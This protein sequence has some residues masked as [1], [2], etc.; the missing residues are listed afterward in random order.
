MNGNRRPVALFCATFLRPEMLHIHRQISGLSGFS[1]V[2]ITQKREG[3]WTAERVEVV[4]RAPWRFVGRGL[5]RWL[6]IP[7]QISGMEMRKVRGILRSSEAALLH[8]FF[9]NV[10]IHTIPLI[11][12]GG[13]PAVISFHGSDVTGQI[14]T[15]AFAAARREMFGGVRLV[16]CRSQQLAER[17]AALGCEASK[18]RI[19]RTVLPPIVR[20]PHSPP[21]DGRWH[22]VQASRLVPKKGIATALRAFAAFLKIHPQAKFTIA[23]EGPLEADLRALTSSLGISGSVEFRG[24]LSQAAL[25]ELYASAHIFLH[26][27]ETV[28]GDVEGIP[29]SLLEAM[30][31]GLP[32]VVTDHGGIPEVIR[33]GITGV[34]CSER[35][36]LGLSRSL[37]LLAEDPALYARLSLSGADFVSGEFSAAKQIANIENLYREAVAPR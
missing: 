3:D 32:S 4:R 37:L 23:G 31:S 2:V 17:V 11:R 29:N 14:A 22:L 28:G 35:D 27:S 1:P 8:I 12:R 25:T 34:L 7:W 24:F 15:P 33:N 18:L 6:G 20:V 5:E 30:A 10:A 16:L 9:G 26:P 21:A 13:V 36:W 19:M